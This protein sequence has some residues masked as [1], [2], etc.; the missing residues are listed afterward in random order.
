[1][2]WIDKGALLLKKITLKRP[3]NMFIYVFSLTTTKFRKIIFRCL[4][5]VPLTNCFNTTV[6]QYWPEFLVQ[7]D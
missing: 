1:M 4:R 3:V 7:K 5:G 6:I 2:H